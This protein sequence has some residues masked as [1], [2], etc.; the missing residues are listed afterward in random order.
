MRK[1]KTI[2]HIVCIVSRPVVKHIAYKMGHPSKTLLG[3]V[4]FN[5]GAFVCRRLTKNKKVYA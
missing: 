4:M 1:S 2:T 3:A 5:V